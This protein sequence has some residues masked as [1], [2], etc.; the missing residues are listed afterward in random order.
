MRKPVRDPAARFCSISYPAARRI[1][2]SAKVRLRCP[3]LP[4]SS[5]RKLMRGSSAQDDTRG[6]PA[7]TV[8]HRFKSL[9]LRQRK[10]PHRVAVGGYKYR[11][12]KGA[13]SSLSP[14]G[15]KA[16]HLANIVVSVAYAWRAPDT[17]YL[18]TRSRLLHLP[19]AA[20]TLAPSRAGGN[21]RIKFK[22]RHRS[23][24]KGTYHDCG[25]F[26]FVGGDGEI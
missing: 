26:L 16:S 3:A 7:V 25:R 10:R 21:R 17:P 6:A 13:V 11:S 12:Q 5:V 8:S 19:P 9:Q 22:S 2:H 14:C 24:Q 4:L 20:Q 1:L 23:E 15:R 18:L